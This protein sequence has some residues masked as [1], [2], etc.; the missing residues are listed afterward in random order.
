M[1]TVSDL[2]KFLCGLIFMDFESYYMHFYI[3]IVFLYTF[4]IIGGFDFAEKSLTTNISPEVPQ[5]LDARLSWAFVV[6]SFI[7]IISKV[8]MQEKIQRDWNSMTLTVFSPEISDSIGAFSRSRET[9][10]WCAML[11]NF[12]HMSGTVLVPVHVKHIIAL[13]IYWTV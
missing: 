10:R 13:Q 11:H 5:S 7:S 12:L 6:R 8:K 2:N 3:T 4:P 1:F 9:R